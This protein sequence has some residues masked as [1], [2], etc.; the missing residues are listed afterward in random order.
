M[1]TPFLILCGL[2]KQNRQW[3]YFGSIAASTAIIVTLGEKKTG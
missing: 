2:I 3:G 1:F